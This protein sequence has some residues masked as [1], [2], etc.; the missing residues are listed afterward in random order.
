MGDDLLALYDVALPDVYGYLIRR[1]G[2]RALAEDLT[3]ETFLA[4]VA[5]VRTR[6]ATDLTPA[7]AMTVARNKLVDHWRRAARE[8][9][10]HEAE[11]PVDPDD[12]TE[13]LEEGP[14]LAALAALGPHHQAALALRYLDGFSV[15]EVA[16]HLD[17][18]V[19]ATEALLVRARSAFRR[20]YGD[21][22]TDG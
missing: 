5:A 10:H 15:N 20:A 17:R 1:C 6:G 13:A 16:R 9:P 3:A 12:W 2:D 22:G 14:A 19:H 11:E 21:G 7:W 8:G 4:A 18:T